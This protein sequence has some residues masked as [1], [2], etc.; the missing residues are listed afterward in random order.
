MKINTVAIIGAGA[1]GAYFVW[2]LNDKLKDNLWVIADGERKER[3][4]AQGLMINN[5]NHKLNVKTPDEAKG[6]DL[7]LVA[8]KYGALRSILD[9]VAKIVDDHTIVMSLLNGVDSEEI[10]SERIDKK[11]I[12]YSLMK[13]AS[14]RVG[15]EIRFDG[16][17]TLGVYFGEENNGTLDNNNTDR[18]KALVDLFSETELHYKLCD[19]IKREMWFKYALNV[20]RNQP[21]AI[22]N[23][24]V[25]AYDDSEYIAFIAKKLRDEVVAV[26]KAK[27][28]DISESES[29]SAKGSKSSKSARYS[30]LQDIDA[31]RHTEV[32]MFAGAMVRMGKEL[33]IATPYNEYTYNVIKAIE[34]R[35]DGK[36]DY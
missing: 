33:G 20:S 21:Q 10:L 32:D 15:N 25:G 8:T 29:A 36:F 27:G 14:Q 2:G 6:V 4:E 5:K 24:G 19:D 28:V 11:Q 31:K 30:T 9:D 22:I 17:S 1:I 18:I 35:N 26:A 13:I 3:L 23:C 16:P 7:L 34:E 12:V